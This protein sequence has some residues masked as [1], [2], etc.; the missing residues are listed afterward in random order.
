MTKAERLERE[1]V[2]GGPIVVDSPSTNWLA[3][4]RQLIDNA[5]VLMID[6][7]DARVV[8]GS[9]GIN[10]M[11]ALADWAPKAKAFLADAPKA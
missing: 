2:V 11:K 4:A 9:E 7:T 6:F 3:V 1:G 5:P 8:L 10:Y